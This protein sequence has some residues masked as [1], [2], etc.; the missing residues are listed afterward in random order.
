ML[1]RREAVESI[2]LRMAIIDKNETDRP[3]KTGISARA[4]DS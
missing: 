4:K 3:H 1:D 2:R